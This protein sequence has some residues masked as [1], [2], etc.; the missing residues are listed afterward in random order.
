MENNFPYHRW[1][2][3]TGNSLLPVGCLPYPSGLST[4]S[5]GLIAAHGE[6]IKIQS[7]TNCHR[8][9]FFTAF[10]ITLS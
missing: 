7:V 5:K 1:S 4:L 6:Q 2:F 8:L 3:S 9:N 10:I